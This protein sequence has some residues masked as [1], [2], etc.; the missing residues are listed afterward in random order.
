MRGK[1]SRRYAFVVALATIAVSAIAGPAAARA[2]SG[3]IYVSEPFAGPADVGAV[4][5]VDPSSGQQAIL[6]QQ[7]DL[8]TTE[9]NQIAFEPPGS[10]VVATGAA[11]KVV[12]VDLATGAQTVLTSDGN[13]TGV[14]GI[15]VAPSGQIVV[16]D[17]SNKVIGIDPN[18]PHAQ[19][20]I[21]NSLLISNPKGIVAAPNGDLFL[22]VAGGIAGILKVSGGTTTQVSQ[23]GVVTYANPQAVTRTDN[24]DLFVANRGGSNILRVPGGSGVPEDYVGAGDP[25]LDQPVAIATDRSGNLIVADVDVD[26]PANHAGIVRINAAKQTSIVTKDDLLQDA[27]GVTVD[28]S[29][30]PAPP[31]TNPAD[32]SVALTS[33]AKKTQS[34]KKKAITVTVTC[35][36]EACTATASGTINVPGASAAKRFKLKKVTRSLA[37][38]Q[39]AKLKLKLGKKV[40]GAAKRA[41]RRGKRVTAEIKVTAKDSAGNSATKNLNVRIKK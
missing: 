8:P 1:S 17:V 29:A 16:T 23:S 38:G 15:A 36:Q 41:L 4:I 19:S 9:T 27:R 6:A 14:N 35:G 2:A 31:A 40:R 25:N 30:P 33:S 3:D 21:S 13:L 26:F 11:K 20:V 39:T 22:V 5:R 10:V 34:L 7:Q 12:R 28:T 24:G 32:T 37:A 18:P